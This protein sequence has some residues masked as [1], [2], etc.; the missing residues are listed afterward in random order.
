MCTLRCRLPCRS[1]TVEGVTSARRPYH[2]GDLRSA[3]L[4]AAESALER[5][6]VEALSLRELTR[7]VGVSSN[8]PRRHFANKQA[9]LEALAL[10]GFEQLGALLDEAVADEAQT[11]EQRLLHLARVHL[12]FATRHRALIQLMF[13]A[14]QRPDVSPALLAASYTALAAGPATIVFGQSTGAVVAGDPHELALTVFAAV[15]GLV[16][17]S[18][19]DSFSGIPLPQLLD[20]I[21]DRIV[22]GLRPRA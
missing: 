14:K 4:H 12:R 17:L 6:G 20:R 7:E 16:A 9:L 5:V 13:A 11:F 3:L 21:V 22:V 15:Q 19:E 10:R 8:A 18:V 2:H 1:D